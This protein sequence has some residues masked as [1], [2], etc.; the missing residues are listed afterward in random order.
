MIIRERM[1]KTGELFGQKLW[2]PE[3]DA[4]LKAYYPDKRAAHAALPHRTFQ[5]VKSRGVTLGIAPRRMVWSAVDLKR[6]KKMRPTA[7]SAELTEAFPGRSLSSILHAASYYGAKRRPRP[8][9][10]MGDP[11]V[12]E[13]R[14]RAFQ[15]GFSIC[16]LDEEA[17]SRGFFRSW[18]RPKLLRYMER[19]IDILGG[20]L[21]IEWED[22]GFE[23]SARKV[24]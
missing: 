14:L 7:S 5:A 1:I 2:T 18:A 19:A 12:D 16:D 24:G 20:K 11:L 6:L 23:G 10:K 8:P 21:V 4:I 9:A 17:K 22:A 15:L 13:I 3:E